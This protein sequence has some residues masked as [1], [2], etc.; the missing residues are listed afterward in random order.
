MFFSFVF[1]SFDHFYEDIFLIDLRAF[2]PYLFTHII[3]IANNFSQFVLPFFIFAFVLMLFKYSCLHFP[4][5]TFPCSIHPHLP[6]SILPPFGFVHGSVIRVP[7]WPFP[8]FPPLS[9]SYLPPGYY[10]FVLYFNV[11]GYILMAYLFC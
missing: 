3:N 7:W 11:S 2:L 6:T 8:F 4:D 5:T 1:T 10:Q 9:P